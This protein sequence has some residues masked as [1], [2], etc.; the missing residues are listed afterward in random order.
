MCELVTIVLFGG[1]IL[2]AYGFAAAHRD[3]F[4]KIFNELFNER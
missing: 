2:A 3:Y 4:E 1:A